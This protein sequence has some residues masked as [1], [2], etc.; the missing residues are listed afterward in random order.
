MNQKSYRAAIIGCGRKGSTIDMEKRWLVNYD[1]LPCSHASAY[2]AHPRIGLVAGVCRTAQSADSFR[3]RWG[4][5]NAYTNYQQMLEVEKPD[6]V[7][8]TTHAPLHA[9]ITIAAAEAGVKGIIVEKAMATSIDE[10][11]RMIDACR[12]NGAELLV[13]HPR[14]FHASFDRAKTLLEQGSIG[15]VQMAVVTGYGKLMHNGSHVF[16]LLRNFFGEVDWV[17]GELVPYGSCDETD[18]P[19]DPD[20]RGTVKMKNGVTTFID[21]A[22]GQPFEFIFIGAE[23]RLVIDQFRDGVALINHEPENPAEIRPWFRYKPKREVTRH[24]FNEQPVK[25]PMLRA[26]EEIVQAVDE[27]R[28][29]LSNGE[30]GLRC[31]EVGIALHLS[32][33]RDSSSVQLPVDEVYFDVV[34]R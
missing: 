12:S 4:V 17:C 1:V 3:Q 28:E 22:S 26:V 9:E 14:R 31:I 10:A 2:C 24:F 15:A 13:N 21:F 19:D 8:V 20:G 34:S 18:D 11:E 29:P 27:G 16:D 30:D 33:A 23:G 25:P 5:E 32:A 6:I 7:S